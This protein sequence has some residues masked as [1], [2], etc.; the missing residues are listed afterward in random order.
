MAA[1]FLNTPICQ[2]L[3]PVNALSSPKNPV[4]K[5]PLYFPFSEGECRH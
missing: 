5:G 4:Y 1:Q 2:A 3:T